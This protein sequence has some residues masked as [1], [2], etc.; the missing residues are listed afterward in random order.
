MA[1]KSPR[2]QVTLTT[3][4]ND[5]LVNIWRWNAAEY[6]LAHA[7][8]YLAKLNNFLAD[9]ATTYQRGMYIDRE[10]NIAFQ[11]FRKQRGH[12]HVIVYRQL[13]DIVQVLHIFHSA[14]NW[15]DQLLDEL[16]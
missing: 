8:Q 10:Q 5:D 9:L 13:G 15:Q 4:A 7:D 16:T 14:Q 2:C 1:K 11:L 6:N 12:G 3:E